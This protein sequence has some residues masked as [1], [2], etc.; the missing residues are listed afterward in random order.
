[1]SFDDMDV[2]PDSSAEEGDGDLEATP[3]AL[4]QNLEES[5]AEESKG[6][7]VDNVYGEFSRKFGEISNTIARLT[8]MVEAMNQSKPEPAPQQNQPQRPEDMSSAQL[9][10]LRPNVPE[11]N[12]PQ[13]ENLIMQAKTRE[14]LDS[15]LDEFTRNLE[16]KTTKQDANTQ[17]RQLYPEL[18]DKTSD[19]Y[20][21]VDARLQ[22]LG[23]AYAH[24][25]PRAVLDIANEVALREGK[26]PVTSRAPG[27]LAKPNSAPADKPR[28]KGSEKPLPI[29]KEEAAQIAEKMSHAMPDGKFNLDR[30]MEKMRVVNDNMG[31]FGGG[32]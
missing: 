27:R 28:G 2:I 21:K 9:E 3:S 18:N 8:G 17:A 7:T 16:V 20:Q 1:M 29:S 32:S 11:E 30:V 10:S 19:F 6:R 12:L 24:G 5:A 31:L 13:L 25:N 14:M 15:K 22:E 26:T 4:E 23:P